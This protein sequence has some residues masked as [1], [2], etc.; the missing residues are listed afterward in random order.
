M[1]EDSIA[2]GS[3]G[4]RIGIFPLVLLAAGAQLLVSHR[5]LAGSG[6]DLLVSNLFWGYVAVGLGLGYLFGRIQSDQ[7]NFAFWTGSTVVV[8]VA[9]A[10]EPTA[11][12]LLLAS[13]TTLFSVY[14]GL[15]VFGNVD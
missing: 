10:L 2:V 15:E 5:S 7:F 13:L 9:Y 12:K 6:G 1:T 8:A 4:S 11:P 14:F 3:S